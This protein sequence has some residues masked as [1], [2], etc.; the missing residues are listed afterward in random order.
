MEDEREKDY[1]GLRIQALS[2]GDREKEDELARD[3][4][5]QDGDGEDSRNNEGP[6]GPWKLSSGE[7]FSIYK[8]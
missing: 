1:S 8:F 4:M 7:V 2:L 6:Q 3:Q 5:N